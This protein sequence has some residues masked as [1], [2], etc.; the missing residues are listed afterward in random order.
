MTYFT[1]RL[2][3][4]SSLAAMTVAVSPGASAQTGLATGPSQPVATSADPAPEVDVVVTG[5]RIRLPNLDSLPPMV[6]VGRQNIEERN[7]T[8]VADVLNELPGFRGSVTPNGAQGSFGQGVNFV[9]GYGLGSN[10]TLVLVNGRRF[11]TS[12]VP[13]LFN[14]GSQGTQVDL[15]VINSLLTDRIDVVSIGGAPIYGSDAIAG[16]VNIFLKDRYKGLNVRATAGVTGRGD[17]FRYSVAALGGHDFLD[18]RANVTL[19]YQHDRQNG[20]LFNDRDFL[21]ENLGNGTNPTT[22]QA[23]ALGRAAGIGFANDGR[24]NTGF[25]FNDSTTDG[26]PGT[27]QIRDLSIYFLNRGGVI[28]AAAGN[29]GAALNYQFDPSGNL[30]SYN[31]GILFPGINASGGDGFR[32]NDFSQITSQLSRDIFNGFA[33]F[34]VSDALKFF[35][36]GEY[37]YSRGDELV[38][39]PTFNSSLFGGT[40]GQLTFTNSSPF[41]TAQARAQLATLGVTSFQVSRASSDLA[42]LTGYSQTYLL[43][44]VFGARGDFSVGGRHFNYEASVN[45]GRTLLVDHSQDVNAQ[46]FINAVNV[47]TDAGGNVVCT[48]TPAVQAAPGGTPVVDAACVPLNLLGYGRSSQAAR[49]Y[50]VQQTTTRSVLQESVANVNV[51]GSP[52]D[53]FGNGV[54]FNIGFEHREEKGSFT[55]DAFQQAGLGRSVAI[56]PVS[57]KYVVNEEFGEINLPIVTARNGLS[58]IN[59]LEITASGRHVNNSINGGFNAWSVGGVI[60]P[61]RDIT[62]RGN[63]TK[64]F[65]GPAITELFL[66][67]SNAF[68]A[69]PDLC[70]AA[71]INGGAAP[72]IRKANCTAFLAKYPNATPLD[73]AA[74]TV[75]IQSGGN[76]ALK[77]EV[78]S[79]FSYGILLQPRFVP[80]L[81]I[82]ADYIDINITNPIANVTVAQVASGCFDNASFNATDPANGNSFCSQIK[83]YA[84]GQGG[85]AVNGGDRGGQVINDT[86]NPGVRV[87]FVNG[88]RIFF[89]GIQGSLDYRRRLS[90]IGLPGMLDISANVLFVRR[91]LVDITGVAP[92]RTDGIFGD[93]KFSGQVNV[94]YMGEVFSET[95]SINFV[96]QQSAVRT[97]LSTDLRE[98]NMIDAFATVNQSISINVDKKFRLNLAVTNL[99]DRIGQQYFGSYPVALIN[100]LQGRRFSISVDTKF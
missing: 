29:P 20:M 2:L 27:I 35:V 18:G 47:T 44:G 31:K 61:I 19:A 76:S 28:T 56:V 14:Q 53:L 57:G 13:T 32:F 1:T 45:R 24:V 78:S 97:A 6:T 60:A 93:P 84:T 91:R 39:Q 59:R 37:F 83:R 98:F 77:N 26:F 92:V 4:G 65:R 49:N 3:L 96:G 48:A 51:G 50:V 15:N 22:A 38:Q 23:A 99:F 71:N 5:S 69:V 8:N 90:G 11:V 85:T 41:L 62:F 58:F 86:L 95:T 68:S 72:L 36:E 55:P 89:S 7:L 30:V 52:F 88:T 73:A 75:P 82:S 70:S 80:G 67:V 87:G 43:R 10:R 42:D 17:G 100:D 34:D 9:N 81:T 74:A 54:G 63:Y 46:R 12:N 66:P 64:S 25:G 79:S 33:H 16:T 40:S 94:R 21:R